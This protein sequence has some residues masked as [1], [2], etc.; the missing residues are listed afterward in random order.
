MQALFSSIKACFTVKIKLFCTIFTT[1]AI[2]VEK[3]TLI[4]NN[5]SFWS[6]EEYGIIVQL[7]TIENGGFHE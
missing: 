3:R 1:K 4:T 7:R 2:K 5:E 6:S